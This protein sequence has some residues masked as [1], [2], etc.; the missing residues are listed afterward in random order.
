MIRHY[1][2]RC[3]LSIA[4]L[5]RMVRVDQ[6]TIQSWE[7][8]RHVPRSRLR[9]RLS[10]LL[11][12]TIPPPEPKATLGRR[13]R[14]ARIGLGLTQGEL[15]RRVGLEQ[16][17]LSRWELDVRAPNTAHRKRIGEILRLEI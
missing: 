3:G 8:R 10:R 7:H 17:T 11:G 14:A 4:A 2:Q 5:A 12:L 9:R 16:Q 1:R 6:A 13:L 15:A